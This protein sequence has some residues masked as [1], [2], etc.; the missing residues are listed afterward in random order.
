MGFV[1]NSLLTMARVPGL[2]EAFVGLV[3]AVHAHGLVD[4][5]TMELVAHVTSTAAGSRYC[6]AHTADQAARGGVDPELL[7]SVWDFETDDRFDGALRAALR[8]AR[9][10]AQIP[11]AVGP[12][13]FDDLAEHFDEDQVAALVAVISLFGWLNR[14]ND[15]LATTLEAEPAA[16]AAEYLA[17]R[18]WSVGKHA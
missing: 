8:L 5:I 4:P 13:H 1:P 14:W 6:Q 7:A 16:F 17:P 12:G 9:D 18:G 2:P 3:R 15:T 10:A 11:N